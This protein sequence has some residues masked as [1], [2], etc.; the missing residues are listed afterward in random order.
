MVLRTKPQRKEEKD[1]T[2]EELLRAALRLGEAHGFAG[3]GLREVARE[4]QIAP[5]SFYRHFEDMQALGLSIIRD[6]A[7]PFLLGWTAPPADSAGDEAGVVEAW[8][9]A[10]FQSV[11][12]DAELTRFILAERVGSSG[13]LR[14]ALRDACSQLDASVL[15]ALSIS[16]RTRPLLDAAELV[17][18]VLL[19]A[20][21]RLL[22]TTAAGRAGLR[23]RTLQRLELATAAVHNLA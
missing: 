13:R 22:D 5:T 3:L 9:S 18:V 15:R 19:D 12:G 4:A 20:A 6:K 7:E 23:Q 16:K 21:G 2:R 14:A 10:M 8:T 11:D 1:R 17:S